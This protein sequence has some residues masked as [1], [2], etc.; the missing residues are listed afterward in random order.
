MNHAQREPGAPR[1]QQHRIENFRLTGGMVLPEVTTAYLTL[2]ELA[3]DGGNAVLVAHGYTSGP[4]MVLPGSAAVE[5]AWNELVGPGKPIDTR[6]FFVV[7]P[8]MLG[9]S[10][11]STNGA[12]VDPATGQPYGSRFPDLTLTD[13]IHAQRALLDHLGVRRLRAVAGPSFGGFQAF[14]WAIAYPDFVDG[15]VVATSAPFCPAADVAGVV[16]R[17]SEDPNW[18]GGDYYAHGGVTH[19][20]ARMR[21][22]ALRT[23]GIDAVLEQRFPDAA[24]RA[25]EIER[26]ADAWAARFDANSMV[27]LMRAAARFDVRDRLS[28]IAARVLL[29]LSSTDRL[30]PPSL[31]PEVVRLL[32]DAGVRVEYCEL[33]S[34]YGHF[35]SGMDASQWAPRLA[36]FIDDMAPG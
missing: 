22:D 31:G 8:N 32:Q 35:A 10:Y 3:P 12:S 26:L 5:G 16:A 21:A 19:T 34:R 4:D 14:E 33:D 30:F 25:K 1:M 27:I 36:A 24:A 2:G 13:M 20:L 7:C 23:F 9:S 11:G 6:R 17:L 28:R 18:H 15:I 29:V